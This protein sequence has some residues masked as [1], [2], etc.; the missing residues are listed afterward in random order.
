MLQAASRETSRWRSFRCDPRRST[1]GVPPPSRTA[2][3]L[4]TRT[5]AA[6]LIAALTI[7]RPA[8]A[9]DDNASKRADLMQRLYATLQQIADDVDGVVDQSDDGKI[10]HAMDQTS[11]LNDELSALRDVAGDDDTTKDIVNHWPDYVRQ[12]Q[13]ALGYLSS[14]KQSQ[15]LLDLGPGKCKADEADL[16]QRI[17]YY[18]GHPQEAED[19][20][21]EITDK[22]EEL[23]KQYAPKL[24]AADRLGEQRKDLYEKVNDFDVSEG[25]WGTVRDKLNRSGSDLYKYTEE[26]R[27]NAHSECDNLAKGKDHPDVR[28]ALDELNSDRS[29]SDRGFDDIRKDYEDWKKMKSDFTR[30]Y[31]QDVDKIRIAMCDGDDDQIE[32]RVKSETE[33]V[34]SA[35]NSVYGT[36]MGRADLMISQLEKLED[37][38][39]LKEKAQ[40]LKNNIKK[41]RQRLEERVKDGLVRGYNNPKIRAALEI[42][43]KKHEQMQRDCDYREQEIGSGRIDCVDVSSDTCR[44]IEIKPNNDKAKDKGTEQLAKYKSW[45]ESHTADDVDSSSA[46]KKCV[47][48][49]KKFKISD[50]V[51]RTY[52]FCP[53]PADDIAA[54]LDDSNDD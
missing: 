42:G 24:E 5:A 54:A 6:L 49:N 13:T 17:R 35:L 44:V 50:Y 10:R 7:H 37:T 1:G 3:P 27:K 52:D 2:S 19:G 39:A 16:Q 45:L 53:V 48:D 26:V 14:L 29:T 41:A 31:R 30:E 36:M 46:F 32:D 43:K 40:K 8:H 21:K 20:I 28:H 9:D 38:K 22:A 15:H 47:D 51:I 34:A 23:G 11:V 4:I 33:N 12:L 25:K 18:V